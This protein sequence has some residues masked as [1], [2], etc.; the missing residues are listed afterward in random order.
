MYMENIAKPKA[1]WIADVEIVT[2]LGN[3]ISICRVPNVSYISD[4]EYSLILVS[5]RD[6]KGVFNTFAN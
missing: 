2:I 6:R 1:G 3:S 5:T 4:F